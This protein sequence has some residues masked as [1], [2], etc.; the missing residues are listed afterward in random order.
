MTQTQR[1]IA[2]AML[3]LAIVH[4][5]FVNFQRNAIP[6]S[7]FNE[8]QTDLACDAAQIA[9]LAAAYTICYAFGQFITGPLVDRFGGTRVIMVGGFLV[10]LSSILFS[11]SSSPLLL[12]LSRG[13]SG[14]SCTTIYL[15]IVK[16][17]DRLYSSHFAQVI[18]FVV[19]CGYSGGAMSTVPLVKCTSIW[20]WRNCFLVIGIFIIALSVV[21]AC[22]WAKSPSI[23]IR[24]TAKLPFKTYLKVLTNTRLLR[25]FFSYPIHYGLYNTLQLVLG[26][27]FLEE[28]GG[29]SS[30]CAA[31]CCGIL[32][33]YSAV[34]NQI[35]G[36]ASGWCQN[37][38]RPFYLGMMTVSMSCFFIIV[39]SL[40]LKGPS[41]ALGWVFFLAYVSGASVP[42]FTPITTALGREYNSRDDIGVVVGLINTFAY[43]SAAVFSC[44]AGFVLNFFHDQAIVR[45]DGGAIIYPDKAY[46]LTFSI[47]LVIAIIAFFIGRPLPETYGETISDN[48]PCPGRLARLLH[49]HT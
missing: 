4:Y 12:A 49:L 14:L 38:R 13:L 6:G 21:Y 28:S 26:K 23:P 37:R 36:L 24:Q 32:I 41:P 47:F 29:M 5:F 7:I 18:G 43:G 44:L 42:A 16:E 39:V 30:A 1:Y 46:A 8:L 19:L 11:I 35:L 20:G 40:L 3:G 27:K 15:S 17:C 2:V 9:T 45:A 34:L 22:F 33:F 25:F 31:T 10:G 48:K